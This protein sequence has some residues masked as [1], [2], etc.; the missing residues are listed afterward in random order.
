MKL[1]DILKITDTSS[2]AV[3]LVQEYGILYGKNELTTI[4]N[5]IAS[6]PDFAK[7]EVVYL[8]QYPMCGT[9]VIEFVLK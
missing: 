4:N 5:L 1:K 8:T 7:R 9:D 3:I 2:F 6:N